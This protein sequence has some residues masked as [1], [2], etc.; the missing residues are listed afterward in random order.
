MDQSEPCRKKEKSFPLHP[1]QQDL[2]AC[3]S[4]SS[5]GWYKQQYVA[6]GSG[7]AR[8]CE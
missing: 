8:V 7:I 5:Q 6:S 2:G 3:W 1:Q 4:G